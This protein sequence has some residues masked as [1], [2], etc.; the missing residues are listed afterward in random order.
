M[1]EL[2]PAERTMLEASLGS[3]MAEYAAVDRVKSFSH[4]NDAGGRAMT[5]DT[6]TAAQLERKIDDI[7]RLLGMEP[8]FSTLNQ[9]RPHTPVNDWL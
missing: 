2:T 9:L 8:M 4:N 5:M 1:A 6:L 7:R 3:H